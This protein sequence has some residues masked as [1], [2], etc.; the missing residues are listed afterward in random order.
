MPAFLGGDLLLR[1]APVTLAQGIAQLLPGPADAGA[2]GLLV[3]AE[4]RGY[5]S[6]AHPLDGDQVQHL[7]ALFRQ[8]GEGQRD[9]AQ[10]EPAED[11]LAMVAREFRRNPSVKWRIARQ[12]GIE[13]TA[14]YAIRGYR[15]SGAERRPG[16]PDTGPA[17]PPGVD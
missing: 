1:R 11:V 7:A 15:G 6:I 10:F 2:D 16:T 13:L 12:A 5:L 3:N 8:P 17:V 4:D 9:V 14:G